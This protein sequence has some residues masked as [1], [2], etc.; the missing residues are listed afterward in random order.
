M[1]TTTTPPALRGSD[2][3]I[4]LAEQIRAPAIECCDTLRSRMGLRTDCPA[5][6]LLAWDCLDAILTDMYNQSAASSWLDYRKSDALA[7]QRYVQWHLQRYIQWHLQDD[8]E[9]NK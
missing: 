8:V 3:Q 9:A 2:E 4:A 1:I 6:K 7:W 5:K